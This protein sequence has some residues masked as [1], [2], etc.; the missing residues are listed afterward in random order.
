M[1]RALVPL[2]GALSLAVVNHQIAANEVRAA[3]ANSC[4]QP[5]TTTT[6]PTPGSGSNL[7][8]LFRQWWAHRQGVSDLNAQQ[9]VSG[10]AL[11]DESGASRTAEAIAQMEAW[12]RERTDLHEIVAGKADRVTPADPIAQM[13]AWWRQRPAFQHATTRKPGPPIHHRSHR[14]YEPSVNHFGCPP[15]ICE[16]NVGSSTAPPPA[17]GK[18]E[19][20]QSDIR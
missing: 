1:I 13:D 9:N 11:G 14:R 12:W 15:S 8:S 7:E 3:E 16:N 19:S 5:I 10:K 4:E 6:V 2:C 17:F 18:A 20:N